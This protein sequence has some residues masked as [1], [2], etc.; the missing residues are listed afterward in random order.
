MLD[1]IGNTPIIKLKSKNI[2]HNIFAKCEWL[3][4]TGSVKDR[5][6]KYILEKLIKSKN[7]GTGII[8]HPDI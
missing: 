3:N 7:Y 1:L 5:V 4:P 6:A 2:N 8:I